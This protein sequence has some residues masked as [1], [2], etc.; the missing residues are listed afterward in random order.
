MGSRLCVMG[1]FPV[2]GEP[3]EPAERG[4]LVARPLPLASFD[5]LRANGTP[6]PRS[7]KL[8][9]SSCQTKFPLMPPSARILRHAQ[10]ERNPTTPLAETTPPLMPNQVPPHALRHAHALRQAQDERNP[11]PRS[12]KLPHSSCQTKFR[13]HPSTGSGRTEPHSPARGNSHTPHAKPSSRSCSPRPFMVSLSNQPNGATWL[14]TPFPSCPSTGSGR[15]E[16]HNP[17]RGN[18]HTPHAKPSSARI[19]RQAQGE[20]NPTTPLAETPTLLMPNQVPL[21]S[22][23]RLRANGT[24]QPRSRKLPHSSCQTKFPLMPF[25]RLR[26]NGTPQPRSR[27]LPHLSCQTKFPLMPFDMLRTNGTPQPRSR[28]LPHPSCQTKFPL[29]SPTP[30]MP[31]SAR[32]L[33]HAQDERNPTTPFAETPSP[34]MPNQVPAHIP[35]TS[36]AKPSSRSCSPR[37]FMVS[38]SNQPNGATWLPA[39]FRSHPS[40]CSGRTEPHNMPFDRL[41]TN[42]T[43]QHALRQA[44]DERNPTTCPSTGS[45]RTEPHNPARGNSHTPHA[46]PSSRSYPP[47]PSCPLPL[48]SFD[49]LRANGTPQP[50]SRKLPHP[51][52]QTKFPLMPPSPVHG[53]LVEPYE[54]DLPAP[55]STGHGYCWQ[56]A[57]HAII[58]RHDIRLSYAYLPQ[59]R[60][61]VAH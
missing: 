41:R 54:R 34:L 1:L 51:S 18:S 27:K 3:V 48:A 8:P 60:G 52:C 40:T 44:Q 24:P 21:A 30:L 14:P 13:S 36:H 35:H 42:G 12:R 29:I 6:Q 32:I 58:W 11:Q 4:H 53:E 5:R 17:A 49:K 61:T 26:A 31:P 9:H 46:K 16:P 33:R 28:K 59:R 22:F 20:R 39:P 15:T 57:F 10:D 23:D 55:R 56:S 43:P 50:R 25:D 45:G 47:H 38:L 7:R 2:R 37:P 19:L